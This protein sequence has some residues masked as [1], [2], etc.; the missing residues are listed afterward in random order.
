MITEETMELPVDPALERARSEEEE[1][2][3]HLGRR[4][5]ASVHRVERRPFGVAPIPLLG[6]LALATL[7][8]AIVLSAA[9]GW[10]A[11]ICLLLVAAGLFSLFV[12]ALRRQPEAREAQL[13]SG[14]VVKARDKG[15]FLV[16][17]LRTWSRA[18]RQVA[19][20]RWRRLRLRRE[21]RRRL[22]PLGEAVHHSDAA[23]VDELKAELVSLQRQLDEA[24]RHESAV[25]TA[26]QSKLERERGPVQSTEIFPPAQD[27]SPAH[28]DHER[29]PQ[30]LSQSAR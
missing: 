11:G 26:A 30:S 7:V 8:L 25:L 23:R 27:P 14:L 4:R 9:V 18:G 1:L 3:F 5:T 28:A 20:L 12:A 22:T 2:P 17:G 19:S 6:G 10:V 15:G 29:R 16:S 21:L 13:L 24:T